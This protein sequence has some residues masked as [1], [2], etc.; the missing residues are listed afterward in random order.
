LDFSIGSSIRHG[1]YATLNR[2]TQSMK[3]HIRVVLGMTLFLCVHTMW[4]QEREGK[5]KSLWETVK[6]TYPGINHQQSKVTSAQMEARAVVGERLPQLKSQ[7]QN[8]YGTHNGI[9]GAFFPQAGLF[10][11]SGPADVSGSSWTPNT[12]ASAT[13]EWEFFAFGK[14]QNK[15]KA[16]RAKTQKAMGEQNA[17]F[18]YLQKEL[19]ERYI[20]LLYSEAKLESN[21]QNVARLKSLQ[22]ITSSLARA[23]IKTEADSLLSSSSYN[24]ALGENE[25]LRGHK[26]AALTKLGELIGALEVDYA[27]SIYRFLDPNSIAMERAD[28]INDS[29]P[30]LTAIDAQRQNLEH[31]G[32]SEG[33]TALPSFNLL[34]GYAYRG[35][36]I[37]PDGTV[38]DAWND[39]FSN[40][41]TNALVGI[42]ITWNLSDLYTQKQKSNSL[43]AQ[44]DSQQFLYNQFES[45]MQADLAS[46][47]QQIRSQF[48]EVQKTQ[49]AQDQVHRAYDMYLARYQSGLIDLSTLLQT[50]ILLEQAEKKHI[51]ASY[52]YWL[53]L[54]A[55]AEL[56]AD[57][58]Y[59]FTNL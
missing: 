58:D 9:L 44:A 18:L 32:K 35:A 5:L 52:D 42:G 38:S 8:S 11:V 7:A 1:G 56:L 21:Q 4:A 13:L 20:R 37:S 39:G 54:A 48:A 6:S 25:K 41:V 47:Q 2:K 24:Q 22:I 49:E 14:T 33:N 57:F 51:Q 34:G 16:A 3:K 23:G 12:Y 53:L 28:K 45:Q 27:P 43:K 50:Q 17:Y 55:E 36:G 30:V 40:S 46:I 59:V 19:S 15:S 10:N 29:H 26:K 31:L